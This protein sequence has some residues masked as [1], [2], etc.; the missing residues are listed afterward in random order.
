MEKFSEYLG[1]QILFFDGGTG[2]VLQAQGLKPGELPENWNIEQPEKIVQLGYGYYLA[3]SNIINTNTFGAFETKFTGTDGKYSLEQIIN[4]AFKNAEKARRLII[5]KDKAEKKS[6]PR[7]IA[8][9]IGSCGKLLKPLGDLEFEDAVLL[10]KKSF[11]IA[12]KNNPDLILIETMNDL[13]EAKSAIIAAKEAMEETGYEIPVIASMVYDEGQKTLTGSTPEICSAVLEGLGV[14]ALGL[15]CSLGPEQ[16]KPIVTRLLEST[17]LPILVKPNAGLPKS[18]NGKTIYDVGAEEFSDIVSEFCKQGAAIAGGCC[19]TNPSFIKALVNKSKDIQLPE[20]NHE[21]KKSVITSGTKIVEFGKE[22]ILIGERINP[23]GKKKLKQALNDN[24]ISYILNEA[25]SQEEKGAHVL[26]V[27]VGLPEIDECKM[28]QTVIK[29]IQTVTDLP[30]QIDTSDPVTMEKALRLYNGKPL[31]NSVNGKQEV[32]EQVFPLVKKYGGMVVSLAL[33]E[34][35]IAENAEDRIAVVEKLYAKAKEYGISEKDIIIDPLAMTVSANDQAAIATLATVKYVKEKKHGLTILGVS[36]VSFGLPLREHITSIFFTM[37]MQNGLSAAIMNPNAN[38]MMKAWT[39][40]KTLSGMDSQCLGY[41]GFAENYSQLIAQNASA[42]PNTQNAQ[43][44]TDNSKSNLHPLTKAIIKGL[45]EA[46]KSETF[47]LLS[48]TQDQEA[49]SAMD[50]INTKIIPALDIIGKDFEQKK[51]YLPQLL[52]AAD[53]AKEAFAVIKDE[54]EKK[55]V[56]GEKKGP[57]VIAT[58]KGDI[59]DIGK[60]IVKVLL[61]NYSFRVIDLGKDV[62]PEAVRDAVIKEHAP[63]AGLSA[64]MTTTVGAMEETI[65]LLHKE[66]PWCKVFVG[67]AV[68]NQDYADKIH[69]DAYT[70]DA[71]ESVKY[72][73]SICG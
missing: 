52:M 35:G 43:S 57:I 13:Y 6:T 72:A 67:G 59:H 11:L 10:F 47:N 2:S 21:L 73:Q 20:K 26:D 51:A 34:K 46:A 62:P 44:G 70:K 38:E 61:E 42:A 5:E 25:I 12:L 8:F 27:N 64:L 4:A 48:G 39:C 69:A 49:M 65:K 36:N 60:N 63:L 1:K 7:F 23:T 24:D 32:M 56:T 53:A 71:M 68:L 16:M 29:E 54:L 17:N 14:S 40:F 41:I 55:G 33:D 28:M 9:D 45:K 18:E 3:G 15:N 22:P 30:L 66:A 50:V 58:V 37:A 31:I 19:G